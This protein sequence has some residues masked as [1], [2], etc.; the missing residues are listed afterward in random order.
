MMRGQRHR[1]VTAVTIEDDN[2]YAPEVIRQVFTQ[3][4]MKKGLAE[5]KECGEDTITKELKQLHM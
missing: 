3:L 4:S 1:D 2:E 5:W